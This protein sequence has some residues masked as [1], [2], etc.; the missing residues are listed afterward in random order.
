MTLPHALILYSL[1]ASQLCFLLDQFTSNLT[2]KN[3]A[4]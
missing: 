1:N 4:S 3:C 2:C